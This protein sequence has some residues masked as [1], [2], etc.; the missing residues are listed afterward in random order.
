MLGTS[1]P[2]LVFNYE[3]VT[4][5]W[6]IELVLITTKGYI[7]WG[8]HFNFLF[9]PKMYGLRPL[10][11]YSTEQYCRLSDLNLRQFEC[12]FKTMCYSLHIMSFV[13]CKISPGDG[14]FPQISF[15]FPIDS[16]VNAPSLL[17]YVYWWQIL[18]IDSRSQPHISWCPMLKNEKIKKIINEYV[19]FY[20]HCTSSFICALNWSRSETAELAYGQFSF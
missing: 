8:S 17:F 14:L 1:E 6:W 10:S 2:K 9:K 15:Q 16:S 13:D 7:I 3:H 12:S 19:L 4:Y 20:F 11:W 18:W 5:E